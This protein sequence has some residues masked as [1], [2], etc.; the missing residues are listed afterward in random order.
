LALKILHLEDDES[1]EELVGL[2]LRQDGL[3]CEVRHAA[4]R[5]EY[6]RALDEQPFDVILSDFH[7]PGYDGLQAMAEAQRRYPDTP[8]VLVSGTAG[9]NLVV[10]SLKAGA[11][12]FVLK[13]QLSRLGTAVRRALKEAED[14][15]ARRKAESARADA[16]RRRAAQYSV[17]RVLAESASWADAVPRVLEALRQS[18]GAA[19]A[20]IWDLDPARGQLRF[21]R[22]VHSDDAVGERWCEVSQA[23][24]YERG[25]GLPGLV[26]DTGAPYWGAALVREGASAREGLLGE[27]A[28]DPAV[29]VPVR[30]AETTTAV[31]VLFGM[32]PGEDDMDL[33]ALLEATGNQLG[34]FR[35][36]KRAEEQIR[37]QAALLEHAR[38]AIVVT[39]LER[40]VTF[41]NRGAE[42][43][44]GYSAGEAR[45]QD[46]A[47]VFS[48][49]HEN[50]Q[51]E[52]HARLL[53][54]G[55]WSGVVDQ[56]SRAGRSIKVQSHWTLVRDPAG[57]PRSILIINT[58][59]TEAKR[60]EGDLLRAQRLDSLGV[61]AGGIAH[62]LNNVL[63]PILM[64]IESLR[65]KVTDERSQR[66]FQLLEASATRGADLV[67][68]VLAF[69]RGVEGQRLVLEPSDIVHDLEKMLRD[70]L[71]TAIELALDLPSGLWCVRGDP[72]QLHQVLLNLCV[73]ARDAMPAGG[74]LGVS[75][76]NVEIDASFADVNPDA[77]PGPHILFKVSDTG[78]GITADVLDRIFEPFF[79]T[80]ETGRGTGLGLSTAMTI[81]RGH[82]GFITVSSEPGRGSTFSVYLPASAEERQ[83]TE[84]QRRVS[85]HGRGELIL[86][87]DDEG[88]IREITKETLEA[89]GYKVVTAADGAE[90]VGVCASRTDVAA[91][92]MDVHMPVMD[93][94]AASRALLRMNPA[95]KVVAVSGYS[96][97]EAQ[98]M[99]AG[100]RLF[101]A[102]PYT[103]DQLLAIIRQAL[104]A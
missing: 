66:M 96:S 7:L 65:K 2:A 48:W 38:E 86:V 11:T 68:Q 95:I 60:L 78:A 99:S 58:D 9:E 41:W 32:P 25:S 34:E 81:V 74:V 70:A 17:T 28:R 8:F 47:A 46:E 36:R 49:R 93:G 4:T 30:S 23:V 51:R 83:E 67:R 42:R 94:P 102:K 75:V 72:T 92:L 50:E 54:A 89:S 3:S 101:L 13:S 37:E 73:N 5:A 33:L 91:V 90:A 12:D 31:I 40:R 43:L 19:L 20:E 69:A 1:D 71:P 53:S 82:Q 27:R 22:A 39:D 87:A 77:H 55:E 85:P 52:A 100:A 62:D 45:G 14:R 29:A 56:R 16:E 35:E 15:A 79:T 88:A 80:K 63:A 103:A 59:V 24:T 44:Y 104:T 98:A 26:W 10:E 18:L 76:R 21:D 84:E 57:A 97:K 61:L 6:V 64:S